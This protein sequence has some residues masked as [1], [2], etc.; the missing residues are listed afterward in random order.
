MTG[1]LNY[2]LAQQRI[3]DLHRAAVK[4]RL[5]IVAR[6]DRSPASK[7]TVISRLFGAVGVPGLGRH[8]KPLTNPSQTPVRRRSAA[9]PMRSSSV[10]TDAFDL[11]D[12]RHD[13]P[14]GHFWTTDLYLAHSRA[15]RQ[16]AVSDRRP[17][18][19]RDRAIPGRHMMRR[20][21]CTVAIA[22]AAVVLAA[23]GSSKQS[24][25]TASSRPSTSPTTSPS[26]ATHSASPLDATCAAAVPQSVAPPSGQ[27]STPT[28]YLTYSQAAQAASTALH[29]PAH[30][31]KLALP[32]RQAARAA[33][34]YREAAS[35]P[36][37]GPNAPYSVARATIDLE[38]AAHGATSVGL[39]A[40]AK[41][42]QR[43]ALDASGT[44]G[45][46]ANPGS[47]G[48]GNVSVLGGCVSRRVL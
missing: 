20:G 25:T 42:L 4:A 38:A 6:R 43:L 15:R 5:L 41:A 11:H 37:G 22:L 34:E 23:C 28:G 10:L 24:T 26:S 16:P 8:C 46:P 35:Q 1:Q 45:Q 9:T 32:A 39:A 3:G 2:L 14:G 27:W 12:A 48:A 31:D 36:L 19:Q 47:C 7:Q 40:C 17:G 44:L 30:S 18:P 33:S 21:I 29:P 13:R